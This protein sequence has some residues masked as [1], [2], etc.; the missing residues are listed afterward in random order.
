M[1][2][3]VALMSLMMVAA[4]WLPNSHA[5]RRADRAGAEVKDGERSR[6]GDRGRDK[7]IKKRKKRFKKMRA[8]LLR[9]RLKFDEKKASKVEEIMNRSAKERRA[10]K[11]TLRENH[12]TINRL[13]RDGSDD[14]A[15]YR[16]A[17]DSMRKAHDA[18]HQSRNGQWRALSS[19]LTPKE[20]AA[21]M[22]AIGKMQR[23]MHPK[24]RRGAKGRRGKG[25]IAPDGPPHRR[26]GRRG[27][28]S[29]GPG[30]PPM[31]APGEWSGDF[32]ADDSGL[33]TLF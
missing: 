8:R 11:K 20:Q 4:L 27:G 3:L 25:R 6:K 15:A 18:M 33:P 10:L 24:R 32:P 28:P 7:R 29:G 5:Q 13:L 12:K 23:R 2:Y 30:G 17:M 16:A 14:Q 9:E 1:K 31:D 26:R 21:L 22:R 19:A